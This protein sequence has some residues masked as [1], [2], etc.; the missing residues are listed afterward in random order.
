MVSFVRKTYIVTPKH[1]YRKKAPF[2]CEKVSFFHDV[3]KNHAILNFKNG[4]FFFSRPNKGKP[5]N[6]RTTFLLKKLSFF[7]SKQNLAN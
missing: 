3:R 4:A 6:L 5:I 7:F 1:S 2:I